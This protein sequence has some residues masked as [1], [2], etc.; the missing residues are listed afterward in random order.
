MPKQVTEVLLQRPIFRVFEQLQIEHLNRAFVEEG[1]H[2]VPEDLGP[3]ELLLHFVVEN[4]LRLSFAEETEGILGLFIDGLQY[5]HS[6]FSPGSALDVQ[7]LVVLGL[8]VFH[9]RVLSRTDEKGLVLLVADEEVET[10][11]QG[12][13][14]D[15]VSEG[16]QVDC[17]DIEE[18]VDD[19][20]T[21]G[22][23]DEVSFSTVIH[24]NYV[25]LF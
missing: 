16:L 25:M 15:D 10:S 2:L 17:L 1:D 3:H 6:Q 20:Q 18:V 14:L 12:T 23:P 7:N 9:T 11:L 21:V 5:R 8:F 19:Q 4:E 24:C 13:Y 22:A